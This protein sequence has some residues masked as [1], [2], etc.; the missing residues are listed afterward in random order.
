[1]TDKEKAQSAKRTCETVHEGRARSVANSLVHQ[2]Q[3]AATNLWG[4]AA[5]LERMIV[6]RSGLNPMSAKNFRRSWSGLRPRPGATT[7]PNDR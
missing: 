2:T 7:G 6:R 4:A 5:R 3:I 1:M